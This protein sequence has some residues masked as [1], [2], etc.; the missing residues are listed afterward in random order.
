MMKI[1][2]VLKLIVKGIFCLVA[3]LMVGVAVFYVLWFSGVMLYP[4]FGNI[5][6]IGSPM[7]YERLIVRRGEP[8]I[9]ELIERE[10][11]GD[12]YALHY[13]GVTFFVFNDFIL[14]FDIT[15]E[16]YRFDG[17]GQN[18]IGV[19]S[20]RE[21]VEADF[22]NRKQN[23]FNW[24]E[25]PQNM[26]SETSEQG[27]RLPNADFGFSSRWGGLWMFAEFEFDDNDI[28]VKMRV[29]HWGF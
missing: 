19:G 1:K 21:E 22:I 11:A 20:T 10:N 27:L 16:L 26:Y 9:R 25:F 12:I 8:Q 7:R 23:A 24:G 6:G 28:V 29:G 4:H 18:R 13:E 3:A 17:R 14:H 5:S 2:S 15:S